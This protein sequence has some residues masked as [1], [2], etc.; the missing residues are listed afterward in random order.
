[1]LDKL[2][3][4]TTSPLFLDNKSD[5]WEIMHFPQGV[6]NTCGNLNFTQRK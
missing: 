5:T 4:V 3:Q 2:P 6:C 1:M